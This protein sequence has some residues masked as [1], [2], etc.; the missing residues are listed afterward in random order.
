MTAVGG[1]PEE[2]FVH[3]CKNIMMNVPGDNS[4]LNRSLLA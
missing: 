4:K 1:R 2:A 3:Y